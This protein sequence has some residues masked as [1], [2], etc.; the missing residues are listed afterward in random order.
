MTSFSPTGAS[1]AVLIE[2][3]GAFRDRIVLVG[4]WVPELL[5]PDLGHMGSLDV[6]LAVSRSALGKNVY[7]TI[8]NR[9]IEAGYSHQPSPTRFTKQIAGVQEPVK[10]DLIGGQYEGGERVRSIQVNELEL[11]TLRGLDL[12]FEACREIEV[13]GMM[14]DGVQNSVRVRVV[15]PEAFILIKAFALDERLKEKDAYDIHF[16]LR[17]YRPDVK[18]LATRLQSLLSSG[19]ARE[20]Y[21][22][23]RA[24][25]ATLESVGPSWAAKVAQEQGENYEQSCRSAFEYAQ[26]LFEATG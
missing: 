11:N 2:V 12:A 18:S 7:R 5:Y 10:V 26:A 21:D 15:Q 13:S 24:K 17:N 9:M 19:L 23:L 22:I 4:G 6:D 8:L 1:H 3:L 20:G 14:P 25:F 16:I